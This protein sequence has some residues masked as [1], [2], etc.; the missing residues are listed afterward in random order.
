[1]LVSMLSSTVGCKFIVALTGLALTLFVIGHFAGNLAMFRGRQAYNS[2]AYFLKSQ[3]PLL[4]T[5][6]IGLLVVF[7]VHILLPL[8]LTGRSSR[9]RPIGYQSKQVIQAGIGV[10]FMVL[11]GLLV[12]VFTVFHIAH[13]TFGTIQHVEVE[14]FQGVW[15]SR[16]LLELHENP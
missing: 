13:Y 15:D 8:W 5:A 11:T 3:G 1:T 4:W 2:Y 6:R 7:V 9:A 12:L 16:S 10:R 14:I